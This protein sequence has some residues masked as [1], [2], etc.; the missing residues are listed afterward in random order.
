[1]NKAV[2]MKS[3]KNKKYKGDTATKDIAEKKR[4]KLTQTLCKGI[5][6]AMLILM[7]L[8][9]NVFATNGATAGLLNLELFLSEIVKIVG[10]IIALISFTILGPGFS[11]HDTSQ[12]KMGLMS[13]AGA[14]IMIFHPQILSLMGITI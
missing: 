10:V 13:L 3:E 1:M 9:T 12:I 6:A 2:N 4:K 8:P 5:L 14:V 7:M 11:Q